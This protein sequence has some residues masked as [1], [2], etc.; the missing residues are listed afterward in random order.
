MNYTQE[1]RTIRDYLAVLRRRRGVVVAITLIAVGI[2]VGLSLTQDETFVADSS[3]RVKDPA[4]DLP[5]GGVQAS[6]GDLPAQTAAQAATRAT[7]EE[8]IRAVK[9]RLALRASVAQIQDDVDAKQNPESNLIDITA[10]AGTAVQAARLANV[11]A[12]EAAKAASEDVSARYKRFAKDLLVQ[13]EQAARDDDEER[14]ALLATQA[15]RLE[16]LSTVTD[17]GEVTTRALPPS[18]PDSPK[19]ARNAILA[20]IFGL[21]ISLIVTGLLESVDRRLRDPDEIQEELGLPLAGVVADH[22]LGGVPISGVPGEEHVAAMD[23]FRMLRT[24]VAFLNVDHPAKIVLVTSSLPDEG[25]TT[26]ATGLALASA[27]TGRRTLLIETDLHRPVQA[28]R[29]GISEAPGLTDLLA[30][31]AAPQDVLQGVRFADPGAGS[32]ENGADAH[33]QTLSC[34]TAGTRAGHAAELLG[35]RRFADFLGEVAELY[36]LIVLDTAPLLAVAETLEIAPIA[37]TILFC[38]RL[39]RTT[40]DEA[41][42]GVNALERLPKRSMGLVLT[43][44]GAADTSGYDYYSYSYSYRFDKDAERSKPLT[45][46]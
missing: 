16:A 7:S 36:D 30:G 3:I 39:G 14:R 8:V 2:A 44:L 33:S 26:V 25:K 27:V 34:I 45:K 17:L 22:A 9:Q 19:P 37:D 43:D 35:S 1:P 38:V 23:M 20:G 32:A 28:D 5:I 24:N 41:R 46:A 12:E 18:S 11:L 6:Q 15:A 21:I 13:A 10:E 4:D 29:L 40:L 42:R 31:E